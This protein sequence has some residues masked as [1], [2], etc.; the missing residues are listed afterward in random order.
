MNAR[1]NHQQLLRFRFSER[2][3]R[4]QAFQ[5]VAQYQRCSGGRS[6]VVALWIPRRHRRKRQ[7]NVACLAPSRRHY[8]VEQQVQRQRRS[9]NS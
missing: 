2:F 7:H 9:V 5:Y 4:Q 3:A 8:P 6:R 1:I